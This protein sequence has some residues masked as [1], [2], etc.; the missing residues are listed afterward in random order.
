MTMSV[1]RDTSQ[2]VVA[3]RLVFQASALANV[4]RKDTGAADK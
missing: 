3:M 2:G 4:S 1:G